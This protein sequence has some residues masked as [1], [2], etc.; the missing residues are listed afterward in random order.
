MADTA[1]L[2]VALSAQLTKFE[3]DMKGAVDIAA[4]RTKEIEGTF[5]KM[6]VGIN[7]QLSNLAGAGG[8]IA[9]SLA[10]LGP[11]G[12]AAGASIGAITLAFLA[13]N[14]EVQAFVRQADQL[15][16][17]A[18]TTGLTVSQLKQLSLVGL[19]VGVSAETTEQSI[20]KM[21]VA[22]DQ[23]REGAGPLWDQLRKINPTLVAQVTNAGSTAE[24]IDILAQAFVNLGS[25][26]EKNAFLR[27][28]FGRGGFAF[29][30]VLTEIAQLKG[31]LSAIA[32]QKFD[33]II[34][35]VDKLADEIAV[36]N[37]KT[38]DLW[39]Q[40]FAA[41][42]LSAQRE[43]ATLW[44]QIAI[45][46][47]TA[48]TAVRQGQLT[49]PAPDDRTFGARVT[50]GAIKALEAQR[51]AKV[52]Q[53]LGEEFSESGFDDRFNQLRFL[54][55]IPLPKPR[56]GAGI[57]GGPTAEQELKIL[58]ERA[59]LLGDL[60][61]KTDAYRQLQ[62]Q[63]EEGVKKGSI[64]QA[65]ANEKLRELIVT[66]SA[67]TLAAK[68]RLGIANEEEIFA[69]KLIEISELRRKA[70]LSE[71]DVIKATTLARKE[72]KEAADALAVRASNLPELTRFAQDAANQFKQFDQ[73]AVSTFGNFE[74]AIADVAVGT[75]SLSEAFKSMADS[76][77]RDLIRITLR[78][79]VTGPLASALS[80]MFGATGG[81]LPG[82][83][84]LGFGGI[85]RAQHGGPVRA[86]SPYIVGEAGPELFVP[87]SAGQIVPS[88]VSKGGMGAGYNVTVN[89]FTSNETETQQRR[90]RG[91]D[92]EQLIVD[93][94]RKR[95]S[96]GDFDDVNRGRF[97]LRARKVR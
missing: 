90:E 78:M 59:G 49:A 61:S 68:E 21:T 27:A 94:V 41:D 26:F 35:D 79:S 4:R 92:G 11:V 12:L 28:V 43:M 1:A 24:A 42:I 3:R 32:N 93:I 19:E 44:Q 14:K 7:N 69:H 52:I 13:L 96:R 9:G 67:A 25:E 66:Q 86:G 40:A 38:S 70:G 82:G 54:R 18:D 65:Q 37:Q 39:G 73:V 89:N 57:L 51:R 81:V 45:A 95:I 29:G 83:A 30:R 36:I 80:G 2:V 72:A 77:I 75:K 22:V 8:G 97:G 63:L 91:P 23:L 55:D 60:L 47:T 20:N 71:I 6:N 10:R 62:L 87:K 64:T 17:A 31:G 5:A 33:K 58:Q 50:R 48:Y 88:S 34:T 74:N 85:G 46:V 76:I 16:N 56:P 84:P 15:R 53:S